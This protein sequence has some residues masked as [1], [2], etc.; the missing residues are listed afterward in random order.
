MVSA[1]PG[2]GI[3]H[4]RPLCQL[5]VIAALLVLSALVTSCGDGPGS[6]DE[7][8]RFISPDP[9]VSALPDVPA[10]A[11]AGGTAGGGTQVTISGIGFQSRAVL[12]FGALRAQVSP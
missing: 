5:S 11:P 2:R 6:E 12:T 3:C 1:L 4:V 7:N 8:R 10:L 9:L